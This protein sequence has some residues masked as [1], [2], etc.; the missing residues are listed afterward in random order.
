MEHD[1]NT[2]KDRNRRVEL[3]K[4]WETSKTRRGIIAVLTYVIVYIF[5][6]Y[7]NFPQPQIGALIPMIGY[8]LSTLT[9]KRAKTLWLNRQARSGKYK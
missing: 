1:L 2:I 8:I 6:R 7:Q 9:I 3:D 4:A 5:M